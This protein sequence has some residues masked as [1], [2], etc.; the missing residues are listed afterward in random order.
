MK[1]IKNT[2]D[3]E[4]KKLNSLFCLIHNQLA[5]F[6]GKLPHWSTLR[7]KVIRRNGRGK[8]ERDVSGMACVGKPTIYRK[9]DWD[10]RMSI[11]TLAD[12]QWV[13][14]VFAH[15][16]MHSYGYRH[17]QYTRYPLEENHLTAITKKFG[18]S[19]ALLSPKAFH[20][21]KK[22]I[23][24]KQKCK[25]LEKQFQWL[26]INWHSNEFVKE[27][28]VIDTRDDCLCYEDNSIKCTC[29]EVFDSRMDWRTVSWKKAYDNAMLHILGDITI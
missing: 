18:N 27:I 11:N 1:I 12:L 24:Y 15:E 25:D 9:K 5:K 22:R 3:Y 16:L 23:S 19:T 28:E 4:T 26:S 14:Q 7:V 2:S 13:A 17:H 6:E 8:S 21:P 10:I 29:D 20:V